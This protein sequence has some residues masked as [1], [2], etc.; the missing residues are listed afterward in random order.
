MGDMI[1][2]IESTKKIY[3]LEILQVNLKKNQVNI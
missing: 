1:V 3:N 2:Y